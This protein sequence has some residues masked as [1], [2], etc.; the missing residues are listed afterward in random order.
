MKGREFENCYKMFDIDSKYAW[1]T[2]IQ[3]RCATTVSATNRT[4]G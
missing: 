2:F 1:R 3:F 4:T